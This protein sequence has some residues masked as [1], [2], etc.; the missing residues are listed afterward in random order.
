MKRSLL[1]VL[2][3]G[4]VAGF[5]KVNHVTAQD[6]HFSQIDGSPIVMNP[7]YA[8]VLP[9]DDF[10][11][12]GAA[13]EDLFEGSSDIIFPPDHL[14]SPSEPLDPFGTTPEVNGESATP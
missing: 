7:A 10:R 2:V 14:N 12:L 13:S 5:G 3:V 8:G 1:L 11:I 4:F 9:E 6:L